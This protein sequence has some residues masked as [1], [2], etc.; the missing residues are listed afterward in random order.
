ME[1]LNVYW[2]SI[3]ER[4]HNHILSVIPKG[5]YVA[6]LPV[7]N[8]EKYPVYKFAVLG[9]LKDIVFTNPSDA[10]VCETEYIEFIRIPARKDGGDSCYIWRKE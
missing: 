4:D 10:S 1:V 3:P 2:D 9:K 7:S 8:A 5:G 6:S